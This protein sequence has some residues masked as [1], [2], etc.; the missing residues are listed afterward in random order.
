MPIRAGSVSR[1]HDTARKVAA[2]TSSSSAPLAATQA[3]AVDRDRAGSC[4]ARGCGGGMGGVGG[5]GRMGGVGGVAAADRAGTPSDD[6]CTTAAAD[7]GGR[8]DSGAPTGAGVP[9]G[10]PA[11]GGSRSSGTWRPG[12]GDSGDM[13]SSL[14][15]TT[16]VYEPGPRDHP[17]DPSVTPGGPPPGASCRERPRPAAAQDEAGSRRRTSV[18]RPG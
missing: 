15:V 4:D 16:S 8:V 18:P 1:L 5:V 2:A 10:G 14:V 6:Q 13:A 12:G 17:A 3:A 9:N 11:G 7:P